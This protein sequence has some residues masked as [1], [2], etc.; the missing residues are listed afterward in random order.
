MLQASEEMAMLIGKQQM[1][2]AIQVVAYDRARD[3]LMQCRAC[4]ANQV[5]EKVNRE[6]TASRSG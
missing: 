6:R 5:A 1:D 2:R 3:G 4:E